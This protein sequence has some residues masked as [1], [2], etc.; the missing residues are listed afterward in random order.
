MKINRYKKIT[1]CTA[2]H[3]KHS[4]FT[5]LPIYPINHVRLF[6]SFPL[7]KSFQMAIYGQLCSLCHGDIPP[8]LIWTCSLLPHRIA[9]LHSAEY[10]YIIAVYVCTTR[11]RAEPHVSTHFTQDSQTGL[12]S[13]AYCSR[14]E[15]SIE[16]ILL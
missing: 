14:P 5:I 6:F 2:L 12:S 8:S 10:R 4:F 9:T 7:F 3:K 1:Y 16:T 15:R 11:I 13:K